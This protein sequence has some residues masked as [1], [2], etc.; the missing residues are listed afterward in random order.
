MI[1]LALLIQIVLLLPTNHFW[2][3]TSLAEVTTIKKKKE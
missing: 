2:P 1:L 3:V